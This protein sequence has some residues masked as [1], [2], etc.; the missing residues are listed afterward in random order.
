MTKVGRPRK[1]VEVP[2]EGPLSK[3]EDKFELTAYTEKYMRY[4]TLKHLLD[5]RID[6]AANE[7]FVKELIAKWGGDKSRALEDLFKYPIE[8]TGDGVLVVG[9]AAARAYANIL[10]T[11]DDPDP[12]IPILTYDNI[13]NYDKLSDNEKLGLRL[14]A[15]KRDHRDDDM[16]RG[17]S[18][19][20]KLWN[21]RQFVSQGW[22]KERVLSA[23]AEIGIAEWK[24]EDLYRKAKNSITNIAIANVRKEMAELRTAKKPVNVDKLCEK[25]G[26]DSK[27]YSDS[28]VN[29]QRRGA[30]TAA[31]N[32]LVK[33]QR[34]IA[35][36]PAKT[37]FSGGTPQSLANGNLD[38]Y[39]RSVQDMLDPGE[40]ALSGETFLALTRQHFAA[41]AAAAKFWGDALSRAEAEVLKLGSTR[42]VRAATV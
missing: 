40:K 14:Y 30:R 24:A 21:I 26:L 32:N 41:A 33:K 23:A 16:R 18:E 9:R 29:P 7:T 6:A 22:S 28:I 3:F 11:R 38:W 27:K 12:E 31:L 42:K 13:P 37:P 4:S 15:M 34:W 17:L 8:A 20:D 39:R 25:H 19:Q 2:T 36:S 5:T 35:K 1:V 10:T